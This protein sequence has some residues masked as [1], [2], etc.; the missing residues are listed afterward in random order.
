MNHASISPDG[1]LIVA[2]GDKSQAF[3][4]KRIPFE[5]SSQGDKT[6]MT[7]GWM[8]I[9]DPLLRQPSG[10]CFSTGFSP[11]G[12]RCVVVSEGGIITVF[13]TSLINEE[14]ED[15]DAVICIMKTSRPSTRELMGAARSMSFSPSPWDLLA[16]AEDQGRV[17]VLDLRNPEFLFRQT[18]ELSV[19][20]S[21][22][23]LAECS[24]SQTTTRMDF[25]HARHDMERRLLES[26]R[27]AME[28]QERFN[29]MADSTDELEHTIERQ[30]SEADLLGREVQALV[31]IGDEMHDRGSRGSGNVHR[32]QNR[33]YPGGSQ[34]HHE[35]TPSSTTTNNN[36][37]AISALNRLNELST[38]SDMFSDGRSDIFAAGERIDRIAAE[39]QEMSSSVLAGRDHPSRSSA[40]ILEY[41]QQ[42]NIERERQRLERQRTSDRQPRRRSSVVITNSNNR[43]ATT[44]RSTLAPIGTATPT[45]STS[46]SRMPSSSTS[47]S[48]APVI[49]PNE[50]M[51][52]ADLTAGDPPEPRLTVRSDNSDNVNNPFAAQQ[53]AQQGLIAAEASTILARARRQ[54]G[55][56][57]LRRSASVSRSLGASG[58]TN[59]PRVTREATQPL[60]SR[61]DIA[62]LER[63]RD[64][65]VNNVRDWGRD[66][67][68]ILAMARDQS[69]AGGVLVQGVG[70]SQDGRSLFVATEN[71][72]LEYKVNIRERMQWPGVGFV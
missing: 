11:S 1:N 39:F 8:A 12:N 65:V 53:A 40:S 62:L 7:Y 35:T 13:D 20:P 3:F 34:S 66:T 42:R 4:H 72:L 10:N 51:T 48:P 38:Y 21:D 9:G 28:L 56:S 33:F 63:S 67:T 47:T 16:I 58:A 22:V 25:E 49:N 61:E 27:E 24:N 43:N 30:N 32:M 5:N 6:F 19:D 69:R 55:L 71:G 68:T 60:L 59:D 50:S 36:A 18:L 29:A 45:L 44:T 64:R 70:W 23:V 52:M 54:S 14:M 57:T 26:S 15:E 2:V 37:N 31:Q 17:I 41:V 46:P